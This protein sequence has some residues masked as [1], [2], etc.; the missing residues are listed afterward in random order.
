M[1]VGGNVGVSARLGPTRAVRGEVTEF[2]F[3]YRFGV[4]IG[5]IPIDGWAITIRR[6]IVF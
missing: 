4:D 1:R 2:A 6:G 3:G 5:G